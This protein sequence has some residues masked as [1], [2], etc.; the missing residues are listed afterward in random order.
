M[1]QEET[2]KLIADLKAWADAEYGRRSELARMLG[3]SRQRI[4]DWLAG[5][6]LPTLEQGLKLQAFLRRQRRSRR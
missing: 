2:E 4:T 1:S 3:V 6:K 5:R